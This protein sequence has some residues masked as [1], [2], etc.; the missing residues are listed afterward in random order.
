[1]VEGTETLTENK[2]S[3]LTGIK[4][5]HEQ[6]WLSADKNLFMIDIK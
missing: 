5:T 3:R 2:P 6:C 1:M 4:I